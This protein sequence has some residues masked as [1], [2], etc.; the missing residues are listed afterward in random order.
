MRATVLPAFVLGMHSCLLGELIRIPHCLT[1]FSPLAVELLLK[2]YYLQQKCG[3]S[4]YPHPFLNFH[5]NLLVSFLV[6]L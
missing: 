4:P 1:P 3:L 6:P 2:L 5:T